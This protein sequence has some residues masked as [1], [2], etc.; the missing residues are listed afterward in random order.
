L[1]LR[2]LVHTGAIGALLLALALGGPAVGAWR[3]ARD[4]AVPT[5]AVAAAATM[6]TA[7]WFAARA[8]LRAGQRFDTRMLLERL[9]ALGRALRL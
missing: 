1:P 9:A 2:A 5:A 6:V 4:E 7:H 3:A 8:Q